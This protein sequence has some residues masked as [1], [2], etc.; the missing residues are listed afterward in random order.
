MKLTLVIESKSKPFPIEEMLAIAKFKIIVN[1]RLSSV[2]FQS[3]S[4]KYNYFYS[5]SSSQDKQKYG[6]IY[7]QIFSQ[8]IDKSR[9]E[10]RLPSFKHKTLA[11]FI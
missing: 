3:I 8:K 6:D 7:K 11:I 2:Y 5:T 1:P 9:F 10:Y 4:S